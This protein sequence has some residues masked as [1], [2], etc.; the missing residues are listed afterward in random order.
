MK[1]SGH[2]TRSM[3]RRY[4]IVTESKRWREVAEPSGSGWLLR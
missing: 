2:K 3:L 4:S 1:V